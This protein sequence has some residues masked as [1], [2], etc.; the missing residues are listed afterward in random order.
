MGEVER[1]TI[2]YKPRDVFLPFH[3]RRERW[4]VSVAHRR[5]GKTVACV[6]DLIKRAIE[7]GKPDGHYAYLAP[8][9]A[10]VKSVAWDYLLRYSES[11]RK[12]KNASELWIELITGAKIRL[13][14]ADNPDALRGMYMDG[15]ILDEYADMKPRLWGEVI[16][17]LLADREGWAV[18]IG[19]PK[20]KNEFYQLY[21]RARKDSGHWHVTLG[22]ASETGLLSDDELADARRSMTPEQYD[23]EFECSFEAAIVGA[24]YGREI[25]IAQNEGRITR[26]PYDPALKVNTAWDLGI[27]DSMTIWF[28]QQIGR[29]IRF[30]DYFEA[31]GY[32]LDYYARVLD[33]KKYLYGKHYAPHDIRVREIGT[34]KSRLEMARG[35]GINFQ[36]VRDIGLKD[37][38][39]AGRLMIPRCIFDAEKCEKGLEALRQYREK[40]DEKRGVSLGP[41]HDWTS[42][43]A[44]AFRYASV[45]INER[46]PAP[47][48]RYETEIHWMG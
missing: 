10:Q 43:A 30:I 22:K 23:Q 46:L 42:H 3:S 27:S 37:G 8:Y 24:Y 40:V 21:D 4:A 28:F 41:L 44:D 35:L 45:A 5:C 29:E 6:N 1:I 36:V 20:G 47:K 2:P 18:F 11:V 16:R 15:V 33:E 14:G 48:Q 34:G 39:D 19:T 32:G 25:A 7:E 12:T 26:V 13:F 9:Y 31:S 17:P 38:I